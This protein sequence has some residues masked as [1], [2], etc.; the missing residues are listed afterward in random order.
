MLTNGNGDGFEYV[1]YNNGNLNNTG[2]TEQSQTKFVNKITL[3]ILLL[4]LRWTE[5]PALIIPRQTYQ[6]I[7]PNGQDEAQTITCF[8]ILVKQ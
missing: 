8:M 5:C 7:N 2:D 3:Q 1:D 4:T 6:H